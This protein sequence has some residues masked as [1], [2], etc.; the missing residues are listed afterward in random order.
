MAVKKKR[1]KKQIAAT[2][3]LVALNK[4][5]RRANPKKKAKRKARA[6]VKVGAKSRA[7]NK[8]PSA[9]LKKRRAKN[10]KKGYYPNP[11]GKRFV[12]YLEGCVGWNLSVSGY[13]TRLGRFDDKLS[14]AEA[15]GREEARYRVKLFRADPENCE[16]KYEVRELP[17]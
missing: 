10:T 14:K 9:A 7:T 6:R 8:R 1:T 15:F 5:R 4:K 11:S 2:K 13:L 12:V 16:W 17:K 3:K